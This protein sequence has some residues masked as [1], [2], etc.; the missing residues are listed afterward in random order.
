MADAPVLSIREAAHALEEGAVLAIPT[1]TVYGLACDPANEAAVDRI[2]AI[3]GRPASLELTIMGGRWED[4]ARVCTPTP[5]AE[6]LATSYL[7]GPLALVLPVREPR[8]Y[9]VPRSGMTV[10]VRVPDHEVIRDLCQQADL[11]ATTSANPHGL[12]A[13][14]SVGEVQEHLGGRIDGVVAGECAFGM[15]STI[16]DCTSNP[17]RLLRTGPIPFEDIRAAIGEV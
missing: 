17:V 13:A 6:R 3:K 16:I 15:A 14:Q 8:A 2:Y 4:V 5:R 7:P 1:D 11:L 9:V 12:P 10:A